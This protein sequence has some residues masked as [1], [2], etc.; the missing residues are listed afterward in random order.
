[1]A[2]LAEMRERI[3]YV[4]AEMRKLAQ[5]DERSEEDESNL[6]A[7][8]AEFNDLGPKIIRE[9]QIEEATHDNG[10]TAQRVSGVVPQAGAEEAEKVA[11]EYKSLGERFADSE[12]VKHFREFGGRRSDPMGVGSF[13]HADA[14]TAQHRAG[15][16]A[17][18]VR[19]LVYTG[20]LPASY[21]APQM[22]GGVYRG[23]DLEGTIRSVL[24][25]GQTSSDAITFF[26]ETSFTNNAAAVA[27]ASATT[28]TTGLKPESALALEE[29]TV[30]VKTLAH[31]IPITRQTLQD[32][33]QMRTYVEQ[34][35]LDG[36][37]LVESDQLLNGDG[38]GANILGLTN[39]TGVQVLDAAAF[40]ADPVADTGSANENFNRILRA[41]VNIRATGRARAN[42]VVVNPADSETFLTAT[43]TSGDYYGAGPFSGN[44]TANLWG[45]RVVEDENQDAGV[46]LVGDG[47][48]AAVWDRMQAQILID[49][50]N[51]Q[52]VRNMLTILAEERLALTVFRPQA[53][54]LVTLA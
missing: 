44:G 46:A 45:M 14:A 51:D 26:R 34:R 22:L 17:P 25:N 39:Q 32:A 38:T 8:L 35:L 20:A 41:R 5:K 10:Q 42:F 37:R 48:M 54:A 31:W 2:K 52:F 30:S 47:R 15:M 53:F 3:N 33:A 49:T 11:R 40:T 7:Y 9:Q 1:M 6:D 36:L 16:T 27:E 50:I 13:Y 43:N 21:I 12:Q 4:S 24:I 23:D 29:A 19:D 28:G 18:E